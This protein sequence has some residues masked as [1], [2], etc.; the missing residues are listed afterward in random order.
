[1][2]PTRQA[3]QTQPGRRRATTRRL[4]LST[5]AV[6]ASALLAAPAPAG[7]ISVAV[8]ANFAGPMARLVADFK[9]ASGH[10]V[11]VSLGATGKLYSQILAGAPFDVLLAADDETPQRLMA[12]G[13]AVAGSAFTYAQGALVLWS[14]QPGLVDGQGAVLASGGFARLALANAKLSPY[15]RAALQVLQARGLHQPLA[16]KLVTGE[17]IAQAYQ[18]VRTGNAELGFVALSQVV[19]PGQPAAGS[20]W[21]VPTPL[22]APIRQDAVLLQTGAPKPAAQALLAYLRSAPARA[23]IQRY[24]Y[25]L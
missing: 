1:M 20:M 7:E 24:G 8:A 14:A 16:G 2:P 11:R 25:S 19:V 18:F 15:G 23:L 13:H 10:T 3:P 5:L 22:Y 4:A 17:S 9:A 12:S 6:L 21:R